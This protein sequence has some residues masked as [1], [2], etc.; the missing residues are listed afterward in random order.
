MR[1]TIVRLTLAT[2]AIAAVA[3][4]TYAFRMIQNTSVGRVSAGAA[5]ACNAAG[6]FTHWAQTN[7]SWRLNTS[8][9]GSNKAAALTSAIATWD[10]SKEQA[11][12]Y[13]GT[14][15]NGFST[16]GVNTVF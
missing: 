16:D 11:I 8:G 15:S 3:I 5:V 2:F 14:T 13:G 1:T 12:S 9:Q 4:P 6:G 7:I 10:A